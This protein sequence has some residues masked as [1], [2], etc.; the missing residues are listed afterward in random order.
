[1]N[2]TAWKGFQF[3][4]GEAD[5][6]RPAFEQEDAVIVSEPYAWRHGLE[7]DDV[8]ELRTDNGYRPFRVLGVYKDY[9]SDQ[10]VVSLGHRTYERHWRDD[11]YSGFGIYTLPG[12]DMEELRS[13]VQQ[14]APE[15]DLRLQDRKQNTADLAGG[16]RQYLRRH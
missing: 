4:Q 7:Q 16:I 1:M 15:R 3:K 12:T 13:Q 8:L 6:I 10:G 2:E 9:G 5:E 14:L 11:R